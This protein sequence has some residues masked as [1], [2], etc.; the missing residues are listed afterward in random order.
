MLLSLF[1]DGA[2]SSEDGPRVVSAWVLLEA[3]VQAGDV[4]DFVSRAVD[5][6]PEL[7]S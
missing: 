7:V 5:D 4:S 3:A 6:V 1:F 2:R